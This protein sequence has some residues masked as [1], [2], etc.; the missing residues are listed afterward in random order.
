MLVNNNILYLYTSNTG[1]VAL[2]VNDGTHLWA[3]SNVN[4]LQPLQDRLYV[5]QSTVADFCQLDPITGKSEW[6]IP[7]KSK[8]NPIKAVSSQTMLYIASPTGVSAL[9]KENGK[10]SWVYKDKTPGTSWMLTYGLSLDN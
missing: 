2:N 6:C 9:Q 1:L 8:S 10:V 4:Q 3:R 5:T 7:T